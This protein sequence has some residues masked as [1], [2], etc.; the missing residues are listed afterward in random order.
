MNS[1]IFKVSVNGGVEEPVNDKILNDLN[2]GG[3]ALTDKGIYFAKID[4][5]GLGHIS[6]YNFA[7]KK[8]KAIFVTPK[9]IWLYSGKIA[10]SPDG[11][12]LLFAEV[13][14]YSSN[15]ILTQNFQ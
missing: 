3:W 11:R 15:I 9:P 2:F 6:Y 5:K 14:Q 10:V 13:D 12:S 4:S 7:T 1:E 8:A